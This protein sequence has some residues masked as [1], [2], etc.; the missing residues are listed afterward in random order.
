MTL[1]STVEVLQWRCGMHTPTITQPRK[2]SN[3][4][5]TST[6]GSMMSPPQPRRPEKTLSRVCKIIS[7]NPAV[8]VRL[9]A[10]R[11]AVGVCKSVRWDVSGSADMPNHLYDSSLSPLPF[12]FT[13]FFPLPIFTPLKLNR[14]LSAHPQVQWSPASVDHAAASRVYWTCWP[15]FFFFFFKFQTVTCN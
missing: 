8:K 7:V 1:P 14:C 2:P 9:P 10:P 3:T 5:T 12:H 11:S 15:T 4:A 6:I 13:H